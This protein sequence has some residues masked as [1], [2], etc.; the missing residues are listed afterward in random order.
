[1]TIIL[2]AVNKRNTGLGYMVACKQIPIC[3]A[4]E[5]CLH[6]DR[7]CFMN[8]E[9]EQDVEQFTKLADLKVC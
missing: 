6:L 5:P 4:G 3:P 1:M 2:A 7:S 9:M 8:S